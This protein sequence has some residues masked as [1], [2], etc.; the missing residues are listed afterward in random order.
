VRGATASA[1]FTLTFSV[2]QIFSFFIGFLFQ[3]IQVTFV[4]FGLGVAA[5]LVVCGLIPPHR[6][7]RKFACTV[8]YAAL[9]DVQPAPRHLAFAEGD[10]REA[11]LR[12]DGERQVMGHVG[13]GPE[14]A[15]LWLPLPCY[16]SII[17]S[18]FVMVTRV[19][20][21]VNRTEIEPKMAG[22]ER[23]PWDSKSLIPHGEGEDES[24][25][26]KRDSHSIGVRAS[27]RQALSPSTCSTCD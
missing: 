9:V 10:E 15:G 1:D 25:G 24:Q 13:L 11:T 23:A 19:T 8:G 16:M 14:L 21:P 27:G 26:A 20:V 6:A 2:S 12:V 3:S 4:T 17:R 7:D 22:R 5:I 18:K